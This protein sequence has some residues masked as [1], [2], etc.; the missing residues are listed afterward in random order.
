M[1][2]TKEEV[3]GSIPGDGSRGQRM[4]QRPTSGSILTGSVHLEDTFLRYHEMISL[5][6]LRMLY[7]FAYSPWR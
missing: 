6:V 1:V 4:F 2:Y 7:V 3:P 5:K